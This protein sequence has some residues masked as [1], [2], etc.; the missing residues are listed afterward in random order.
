[1]KSI[2]TLRF[3]CIISF[4]LLFCP[5][6][7]MCNGHGMKKT[8]QAT[9]AIVD[10]TSVNAS[11]L[12]VKKSMSE[13]ENQEP[14]E[15]YHPTGFQYLYE[16][17]DDDDSQNAFE[18]ATMCTVYFDSSILELKNS[19]ITGIRKN[20]YRGF[21][22]G[23]KNFGFLFIIILTFVNLI[24]SFTQKIK[25]VFKFS[26]WILILLLI[27]IVC[28]FLEGHFEEVS[29][30]KWG[31][32]VFILVAIGVLVLSKKLYHENKI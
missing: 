7:D 18:I 15:K 10:A 23:L 30:I 11:A 12:E 4:L 28:L 6:Y 21:F 32:Y 27:T 29:Q 5:F 25:F 31:Y 8:A 19:I 2:F 14:I 1:M 22:F 13:K 17:I 26:K 20:D 16:M 9:D 3:L 24:L